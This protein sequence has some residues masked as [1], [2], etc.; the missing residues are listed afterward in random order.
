MRVLSTIMALG[1]TT[2][3]ASAATVVLDSFDS[4]QVVVDRPTG[5]QVNNSQLADAS[6]FG[7][8]RD[9]SVSNDQGND[10]ATQVVVGGGTLAFSNT[11][12]NSGS[13]TLTYDG[14]DSPTSVNT[15]G[16]GGLDLNFGKKGTG[17]VFDVIATD[18]NL[19]LTVRAWDMVGGFSEFSQAFPALTSG[20][21]SGSFSDFSGDADLSNLGALQ[22]VAG[23]QGVEDL[24]AGIRSIG[25]N[26]VP[27]PAAGFL[28][29]GVVLAGAAVGRKR[30]KTA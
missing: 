25:V 28:L 26:V 12:G 3:G 4:T 15:T 27:L 9:L 22:F 16:L 7:G 14:D 30:R 11:F 17:F 20:V 10:N 29:G 24:D 5:G 19:L 21:F 2:T 18:F 1:L 6:V 8:F 23:G 13:G